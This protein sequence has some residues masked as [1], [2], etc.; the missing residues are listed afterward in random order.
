MCTSPIVNA[1]SENKDWRAVEAAT[2]QQGDRVRIEWQGGGCDD[3]IF[4][5]KKTSRPNSGPRKGDIYV[6][7]KAV[8]EISSGSKMTNYQRNSRNLPEDLYA[9]LTTFFKQVA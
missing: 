1:T 3:Y 2:L 9:S 6:K 8:E 4:E 5:A 7:V